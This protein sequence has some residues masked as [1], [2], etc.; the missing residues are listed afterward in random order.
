MVRAKTEKGAATHKTLLTSREQTLE[1]LGKAEWA[2]LNEGG[3]GF[4]RVHYSP[5]LLAA[6]ESDRVFRIPGV[7]LAEV[8]SRRERH[9]FNYLFTWRSPALG[10]ALGS[11]HALELGFVFG[12]NH[13]PGMTAFAGSGPAAE[14]AGYHQ[15]SGRRPNPG[16]RPGHWG[17]RR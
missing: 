14:R 10:G 4:Y 13:M 2:L 8:Q 3:H 12:T 11:C 6:I 1:L 17:S 16:R 9:T 7:R 15:F 5:E